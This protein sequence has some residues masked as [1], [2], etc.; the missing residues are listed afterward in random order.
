MIDDHAISSAHEEKYDGL[1]ILN[2]ARTNKVAQVPSLFATIA[3][4]WFL[5]DPSMFLWNV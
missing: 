5:S 4:I 2:Y 3:L 1:K